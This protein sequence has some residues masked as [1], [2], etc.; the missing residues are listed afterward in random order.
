MFVVMT[1][2]TV[3]KM[4]FEKAAP[5]CPSDVPAP[6]VAWNILNLLTGDLIGESFGDFLV[7][8]NKKNVFT[9]NTVLGLDNVSFHYCIEIKTYLESIGVEL[10]Y[11]LAYSPDLNPIENIFG[12]IKQILDGIRPGALISV[13][14]KA[15]I[16]MVIEVLGEFTNYYSHFGRN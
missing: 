3:L 6:L 11:L 13:Q 4:P 8:C 12:C 2:C 1:V 15:N 9:P 7:E 5:P 10:F 16:S 14:L